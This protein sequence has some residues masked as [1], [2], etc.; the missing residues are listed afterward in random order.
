MIGEKA[1][2]VKLKKLNALPN[3]VQLNELGLLKLI[4]DKCVPFSTDSGASFDTV[5]DLYR[6]KRKS[7]R[8]NL[9]LFRRRAK[10][11]LRS[12]PVSLYSPRGD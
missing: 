2:K 1:G 6:G 8:L 10:V 7:N 11:V 9:S 12:K 3:I 5:T 4:A